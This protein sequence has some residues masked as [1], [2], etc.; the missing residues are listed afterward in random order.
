MHPKDAEGIANSIDP[1]QTAPRGLGLHCL[2]RPVCP[3]IT[4]FYQLRVILEFL[5]EPKT[6][7]FFMRTAKPSTWH[8]RPAKTQNQS[9]RL[10]SLIR[11]CAVRMKKKR[12][13]RGMILNRFRPCLG[14]PLRWVLMA[15]V[16]L[17]KCLSQIF[18]WQN[19]YRVNQI[20]VLQSNQ[21]VTLALPEHHYNLVNMW[22]VA[23][24]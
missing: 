6:E 11:A 18:S 8:V 5:L 24:L 2:P 22:S 15:P 10:G 14:W 17:P 16:S 1:D 7:G 3:N 13:K 23:V 20:L 12:K 4:I 21:A 9:A 19:I